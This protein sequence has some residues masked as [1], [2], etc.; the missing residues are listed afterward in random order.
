MLSKKLNTILNKHLE[1][2]TTFWAGKPKLNEKELQAVAD[3]AKKKG[4]AIDKALSSSKFDI[5]Q[6]VESVIKKHKK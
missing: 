5:E 1:D 6:S 4:D 2:S 3:Y